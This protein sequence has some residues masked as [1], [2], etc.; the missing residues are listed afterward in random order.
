MSGEAIAGRSARVIAI[1]RRAMM[2][3]YWWIDELKGTAEAI[4]EHLA[5]Q[6]AS[7]VIGHHNAAGI[8]LWLRMR[9]RASPLG[10]IS[11]L[12]GGAWP[13]SPEVSGTWPIGARAVIGLAADQVVVREIPLPAARADRAGLVRLYLERE[14]PLALERFYYTHR[15]IRRVRGGEPMMC[16]V[17]VA[18]RS[19][20]DE[21]VRQFRHWGLKP[22]IVG[23]AEGTTGVVGNVLPSTRRGWQLG[24]LKKG[25]RRW[26]RAAAILA[27]VWIGVMG[28]QW[29]LE[30]VRVNRV[31]TESHNAA[32]KVAELAG[33][34]ERAAMPAQS[35]N[36]IMM[37]PDAVD[38]LATL[39]ERVPADSWTY[40]LSIESPLNAHADVK[41]TGFAPSALALTEALE[42]APEL[43]D[44][45][46][47]NQL[48]DTSQRTRIQ[49][50]L[51][52]IHS[53][54][55]KSAESTTTSGGAGA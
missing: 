52:A 33:R 19:T 13:D 31:A 53:L 38:V 22:S 14:L 15:E 21:L 36:Q 25:D 43:T 2:M 47:V 51:H 32:L 27:C 18:H 20:V 42:R 28:V 29:A 26:A 39:S 4:W 40:E 8:E 9:R 54:P 30:R 34:I 41:M 5:P 37:T 55:V 46:L 12:P 11:R 16:Q 10:T 49:L 44:V 45:T 1:G 23:L 17:L 24:V 7:L 50:T 6:A 48:P 35:L 3:W